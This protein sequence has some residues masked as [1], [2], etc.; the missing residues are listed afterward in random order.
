MHGVVFAELKRFVT[1]V[2]SEDVWST[3]A[4]RAGLAGGICLPVWVQNKY[5]S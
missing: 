2:H 3:L 5:K 4:S 1:Q